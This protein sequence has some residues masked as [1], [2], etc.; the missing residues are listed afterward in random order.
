M[1]NILDKKGLAAL[2]K[3]EPKRFRYFVEEGVF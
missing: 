2:K 1:F 3:K